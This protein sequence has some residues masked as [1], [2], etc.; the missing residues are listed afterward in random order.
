MN[1]KSKGGKHFFSGKKLVKIQA[2]WWA[3]EYFFLKNT[4]IHT[5]KG[6]FLIIFFAA[7]AAVFILVSANIPVVSRAAGAS[8][9]L[10]LWPDATVISKGQIFNL[11]IVMD[12]GGSNVVAARSIIDYDTSSFQL[13]SW[14]TS[15]SVF[16]ANNACTYNGNS[17]QEVNSD[18]SSGTVDFIFAKPTP[19]VNTS[20]GIIANLSFTALQNVDANSHINIRFFSIGS[21]DTSAVILDDGQGTN[22]LTNVVNFPNS[23]INQAVNSSA[24]VPTTINVQDPNVGSVV[25]ASGKVDV[26]IVKN[27]SASSANSNNAY[28]GSADS[29]VTS[30]TKTSTPNTGNSGAGLPG[31]NAATAAAVGYY[32]GAA[33]SQ[34]P[35]IIDPSFYVPAAPGVSL[36]PAPSEFTNPVG[37]NSIGEG[38]SLLMSNLQKIVVVLAIIFI[39]IAG[40]MYM[41]SAGDETMIKR[42]KAALLGSVIGLAIILA[43]PAFLKEI[44]DIFALKTAYQSGLIKNA[45]TLQQ[46]AGNVLKF[47]LSTVGIIALIG[48]IVGGVTY[49]T[50]YSN[51][52]RLDK[53]K[54]ILLYSII[55]TVVAFGAL[56]IVNQVAALIG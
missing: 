7:A 10:Q 2:S 12:T 40:I 43:A 16:A 6:A 34:I 35:S 20:S 17:C 53:S 49:I 27:N 37:F 21:Y 24:P 41:V 33:A 42:A 54:K 55:G 44:S 39:I 26:A 9:S 29:S 48:L 3:R 31:I 25:G 30:V 36:E 15:N 47:L 18:P 50:A 51:E 14:D 5:W 52:E 56:I 22:I 28:S 23:Y 46:I 19:G 1:I 32:Q 45:P 38:L 11:K 8:A 13:K 4:K